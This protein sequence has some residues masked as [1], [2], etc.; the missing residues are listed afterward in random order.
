MSA[1]IRQRLT[2]ETMNDHDFDRYWTDIGE[3]MA[4]I[5]AAQSGLRLETIRSVMRS[6]FDTRRLYGALQVIVEQ[7]GS[8]QG[9]GRVN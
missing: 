9:M 6:A 1:L 3:K 5:I 2:E 8:Q 4:S 7:S